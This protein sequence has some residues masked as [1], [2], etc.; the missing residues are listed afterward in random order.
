MTHVPFANEGGLHTGLLQVG[1]EEDGALGNGALIVHHAMMV[2]VLTGQDMHGA[3]RWLDGMEQPPARINRQIYNVGYENFKVRELAEK[4]RRTLGG[5]IDIVCTPSDDQR[6]YHVSS[7][8][9]K[10][11][12]G[13]IPR[14]TIEDDIG[15]VVEFVVI[16]TP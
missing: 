12:L 5:N 1:G 9:I 2:H 8:K 15:K 6:S 14:F 11:E 16:T 10:Q 13:F 7:E 3:M 4:V